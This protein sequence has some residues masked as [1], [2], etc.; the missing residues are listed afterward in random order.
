VFP[1]WPC[2]F[3]YLVSATW[4]PLSAI[5]YLEFASCRPPGAPNIRGNTVVFVI[6]SGAKN[7][8]VGIATADSSPP[9]GG[10]E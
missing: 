1:T 9:E 8:A 4:Y 5:F 2:P 3:S 7:L 6:L 10:S